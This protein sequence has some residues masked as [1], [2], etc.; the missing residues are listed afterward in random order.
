M[1]EFLMSPVV[2]INSRLVRKLAM[3]ANMRIGSNSNALW[4]G[5]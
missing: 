2:E 3:F 4:G 5:R 1:I